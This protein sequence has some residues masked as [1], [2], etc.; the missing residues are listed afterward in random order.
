MS[1]DVHLRFNQID[2]PEEEKTR[3]DFI[4]FRRRVY[5]QTM[6]EI[7]RSIQSAGIDGLAVSC[8]DGINR[9]LYPGIYILSLDFEEQ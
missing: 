3:P 8:G 6:R 9:V 7:Y 1:N 2:A 5:H 4:N